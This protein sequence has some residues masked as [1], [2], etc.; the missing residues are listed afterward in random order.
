M[1]NGE[2]KVSLKNEIELKFKDVMLVT[3]SKNH[4]KSNNRDVV[5][6]CN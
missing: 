2:S 3:P 6:G 1:I 5:D 4:G